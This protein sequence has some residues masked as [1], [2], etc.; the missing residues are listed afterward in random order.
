MNETIAEII[1][2]AFLNAP[3][4][5]VVLPDDPE[6]MVMTQSWAGILNSIPAKHLVDLYTYTE[7]HKSHSGMTTPGDM[8]KCWAEYSRQL[9]TNDEKTIP[10]KAES[11]VALNKFYA[12]IKYTEQ[13][14]VHKKI[15]KNH[16]EWIPQFQTGCYTPDGTEC[17]CQL[18]ANPMY[19]YRNKDKQLCL[20][21]LKD[22]LGI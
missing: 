8:V 10:T 14:L 9:R 18:S 12:E 7:G 11:L 13:R 4:P 21:C 5:K 22:Y 19:I 2:R 16:P 17:Y 3:N 6:V 15:L 1:V 20:W